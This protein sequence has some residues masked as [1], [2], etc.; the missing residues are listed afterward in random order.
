MMHATDVWVAQLGVPVKADLWTDR[1][2]ADKTSG[3]FRAGRVITLNEIRPYVIDVGNNGRLSDRGDYWTTK[4]D[5]KRLFSDTIPNKT[6]PWAKRRVMLYIHGG[7]NSEKDVAKRIVAFRD[8]CLK[9]EIYPLHI[10]WESDWSSSLKNIFADM[11]TDDDERAAGFLDYL[12]EGKDRAIEIGAAYPG[13]GL[14]AEMQENARLASVG[15]PGAMVL[16]AKYVK[17]AITELTGK[18]DNWELHVV[19]HSAGSILLAHAVQHLADLGVPW[20][21]L[22]FMAPAMRM[23]Q[24]SNGMMS[25]IRGKK[26]PKPIMYILSKVGELD[27]DVGP[28]GK[29]LLYLVS[30]AFESKRGVPLL[31]MQKFLEEDQAVLNFLNDRAAIDNLPGIVVAG[32]E[33]RVEARSKSDTHGGFDNDPNTMNSILCRILGKEPAPAFTE[34]DLEF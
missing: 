8:V 22:Q 24:F 31:G 23:D 18:T 26:C 12:R 34:R 27:D 33:G 21:T 5:L 13:G 15:E 28:Y 10:M 11:F 29:S 25:A 2:A 7:L 19:A 14:W 20:K 32:E 16:V 30:N 3:T 1:K 17:E 6:E 4:D 9:N